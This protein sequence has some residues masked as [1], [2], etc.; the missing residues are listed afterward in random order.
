MIATLPIRHHESYSQC[1][2][3]KRH[4]EGNPPNYFKAD[5]PFTLLATV[6]EVTNATD[7]ILRLI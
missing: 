3:T 4:L 7:A 5:S 2:G 6:T 1:Y